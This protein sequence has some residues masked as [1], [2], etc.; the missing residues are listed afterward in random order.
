MKTKGEGRSAGLEPE[1][2]FLR[3]SVPCAFRQLYFHPQSMQAQ[4]GHGS[5]QRMENT[6]N[7]FM[8]RIGRP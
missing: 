6:G 1:A 2:G 8:L 7:T 5:G 3:Q 4:R